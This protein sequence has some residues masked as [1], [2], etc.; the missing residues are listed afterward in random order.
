MPPSTDQ[1][2]P[3]AN[4]AGEDSL[5]AALARLQVV[6]AG[7]AAVAERLDAAVATRTS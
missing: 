2:T 3:R 6:D 4:E 5:V 7:L 1:S